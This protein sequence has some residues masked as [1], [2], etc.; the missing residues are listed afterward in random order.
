[1][2]FL[3]QTSWS[4]YIVGIGIGVLSWITFLISD[5]PLACSTSFANTSGMIERLFRGKK[6]EEKAYYR[7]I[8]LGIDWQWM[9]VLGVVFG[10]LASALLSG[11]FAVRWVPSTWQSAF[12]DWP[13]LR[14]LAAVMGGAFLGFGARWADGC[15]SGHGISG[16]LQLAVSSWISAVFFFIGGILAALLLFNLIG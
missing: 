1:M 8:G 3:T 13:G 14:I 4:P 6:V 7:K 10:A 5:K 2:D 9:L 12:G 11:D 16:T 15:T